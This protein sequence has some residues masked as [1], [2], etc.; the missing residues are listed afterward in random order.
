MNN[1]VDFKAIMFAGFYVSKNLWK[2]LE[3]QGKCFK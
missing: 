2:Y 1:F 3:V